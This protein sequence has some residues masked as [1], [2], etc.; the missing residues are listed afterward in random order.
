VV[1]YD[2]EELFFPSS[3]EFCFVDA[4]S[5]PPVATDS[6]SLIVEAEFICES[7]FYKILSSYIIGYFSGSKTDSV[8]SSKSFKSITESPKS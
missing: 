4:P 6:L 7:P 2:A 5:L 8:S 1:P 3:F